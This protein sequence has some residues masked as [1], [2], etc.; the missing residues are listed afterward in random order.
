MPPNERAERERTQQAAASA[1]P[2]AEFEQ[3]WQQGQR[4]SIQDAV[5]LAVAE[6]TKV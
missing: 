6:L 2:T 4:L 3:A 1:V 5:E